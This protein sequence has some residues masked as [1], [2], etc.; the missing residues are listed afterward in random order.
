MNLLPVAAALLVAWIGTGLVRRFAVRAGMLDMPNARSMHVLPTPRGG[1]VA[2][3]AGIFA[4]VASIAWQDGWSGAAWSWLVGG[5][6]IALVGYEDDRRGLSAGT[7][8]VVHGISAAVLI[9][10]VELGPLPMP[11]GPVWLGA[12][13]LVLAWLATVWSVNL[14]NFMDGT[15]GIAA[16]QAVFVF[17]SAACI[18]QFAP[19][20]DG[21]VVLLA[22]FAATVLGFLAWNLPPA[23][24]FMG[25]AGSGFLGYLV[26][27]AALLV[28]GSGATSLWTW[29]VLH[30]AFVT[31]ATVTLLVR[32][33]N[34][35]RLSQPH[36]SHVYQRLG[37][38]LESHR[39]VLVV[40]A[41]VNIVWL[42]PLAIATVIWPLEGMLIAGIALLPLVGAALLLGAGHPDA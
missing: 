31:D 23:R 38:R 36:R 18:E 32:A 16:S 3:V 34:G 22:V 2:I 10:S 41:V 14:F 35:Q 9:A 5:F 24:I 4:G 40:Y 33:A 6:A 7:R 39:A 29:L 28:T 15:D 30:G 19:G 13:G 17:G 12:V 8:L 11:Q 42:L 1:G 21:S 20:G 27:A 25:D 37:R 26:A